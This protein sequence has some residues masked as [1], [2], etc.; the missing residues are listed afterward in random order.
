MGKLQEKHAEKIT[1][2]RCRDL[3]SFSYPVPCTF[4]IVDINTQNYV[5]IQEIIDPKFNK[6]VQN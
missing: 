6:S 3:T 5:N 4:Y 1:I 2:S